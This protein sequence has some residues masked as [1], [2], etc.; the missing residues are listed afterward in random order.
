MKCSN[1]NF[2]S[3]ILIITFLILLFSTYSSNELKEMFFNESTCYK[4]KA[5][6]KCYFNPTGKTQDECVLRCLAGKDAWG[7]DACEPISDGTGGIHRPC[8]EICKHK[9]NK[10]IN[11]D[12][13]D[14]NDLLMVIPY[15]KKVKVFVDLNKINTN[16]YYQVFLEYYLTYNKING[17]YYMPINMNY[18][19]NNSTTTSP[20]AEPPYVM[21]IDNLLN[22]KEYTFVVIGQRNENDSIYKKISEPVQAMCSKNNKSLN[23]CILLSSKN[24]KNVESDKT[25]CS[26]TTK[27]P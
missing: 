2:L 19:Q 3:V 17:V 24:S 26:L 11:P 20:T 7:G 21:E 10:V 1:N 22:D 23:G 8:N 15:D 16:D 12:R 18:S 13:E 6:K 27:T 4:K 5:K 9:N 25:Y 14:L